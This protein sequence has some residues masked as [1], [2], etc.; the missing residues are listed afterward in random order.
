MDNCWSPLKTSSPKWF[1]SQVKVKKTGWA[2]CRPVDLCLRYL[3]T[4]L[5]SKFELCQLHLTTFNLI[6]CRTFHRLLHPGN[7]LLQNLGSRFKFEC[8]IGM[9]GR[10]WIKSS[11]IASTI[12]IVNAIKQITHLNEQQMQQHCDSV[13]ETF[14]MIK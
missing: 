2:F 12:Y 13:L 1:A 10:I 5:D 7:K 14:V 4:W 3:F 9:N 6:F 11:S 8:A